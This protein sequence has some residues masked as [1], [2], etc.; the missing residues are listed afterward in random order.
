MKSENEIKEKI[1]EYEKKLEEDPLFDDEKERI[2]GILDA[3][4][5]VLVGMFI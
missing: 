2:C 3:L 4:D 5:W 1:L